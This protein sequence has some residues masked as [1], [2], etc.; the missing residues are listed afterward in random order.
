MGNAHR[1]PAPIYI[2][3]KGRHESRLTMKALDRMNVPYFVIVEEAEYPAY[4]AVIDP[5]RLLVLDPAYQ[6]DYDACDDLGM[7]KPKGSGPARNFAWDHAQAHGAEW[8]WTVDDNI[9]AFYRLN[10]NLKIPLSHGVGFI[11]MEDFV[12]R[13]TNVAM[14]GPQY[15]M[16]APRKAKW[17]PFAVNTRIYSCNLIRTAL[18]YRWRARF[19]EDTDLSL[20]ML[21]DGWCTI[22][23]NAFLQDK[24]TTLRMKGGNT[25]TVYVGGTLPKSQMIADLHPDVARVI[26]RFGRWHHWADYRPFKR[27]K[28]IR[29]PDL[30]IPTEPDEYGMRLVISP[31][32]SA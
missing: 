4:A 9:Q 21:K 13:Y 24:I 16:F 30:D 12:Q 6:R 17:P 8:H 23:F 1:P 22:L 14:A 3:S 20:R 15:E 5:K 10:H 26:W 19:N 28:L 27:Q 18:P 7:S 11:A 29:R 32:T 2:P 31:K 25:D